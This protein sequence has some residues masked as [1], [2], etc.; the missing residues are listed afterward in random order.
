M[1]VAARFRPEKHRKMVIVDP[2]HGAPKM[3]ALDPAMTGLPPSITATGIDALTHAVEAFVGHWARL[4]RR[5]GAVGRADLREPAHRLSATAE[6]AAARERALASTY[7]GNAFT[8]ANVGYV[9][10][11]AHQF[12]GL[13]HTPHGLANAIMLP[14][15]LRYSRAAITDRLALAG[16]AR[17]PGRDSERRHAGAEVPGNRGALNRDL[18]H[19]TYLAALKEVD[20]PNWP[21]PPT[22]RTPATRCRA[23]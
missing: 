20:I 11:I 16:G 7:A 12:G 8:R 5:H 22:K 14:H 18:R 21:R 19:P 3:A 10:A 9:H 13:Y 4:L 15:V 6:P 1:T 2:R 17:Q 23:T